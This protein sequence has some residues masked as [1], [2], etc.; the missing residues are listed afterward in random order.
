MPTA[1]FEYTPDSLFT[2][3]FLISASKKV[4]GQVV[5]ALKDTLSTH[6]KQPD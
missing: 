5:K 2:F 6:K 4:A 3:I 1:F